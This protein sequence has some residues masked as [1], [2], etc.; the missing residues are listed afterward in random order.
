MAQTEA[1]EL[2]DLCEIL[3]NR[4]T[5]EVEDQIQY[6]HDEGYYQC[7][8]EFNLALDDT[9]K[10]TL[11]EYRLEVDKAYIRQLNQQAFPEKGSY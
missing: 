11:L 10:R 5:E 3:A 6:A 1:E 7:K 2:R 8:V 9:D 4:E